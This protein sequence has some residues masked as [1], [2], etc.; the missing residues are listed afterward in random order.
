[1]LWNMASL[2]T[3]LLLGSASIGRF[4]AVYLPFTYEKYFCRSNVVKLMMI[5]CWSHGFIGA[6]ISFAGPN[7]DGQLTNRAVFSAAMLDHGKLHETRFLDN[8]WS[9]IGSQLPVLT[10]KRISTYFSFYK[11]AHVSVKAYKMFPS[12]G[13]CDQNIN[14]S[15]NSEAMRRGLLKT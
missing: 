4:L 7:K 11:P 6:S 12:W 14:D 5:Y 9:K 8:L 15:F 10:I 13:Y 2:T 3:P 1:M